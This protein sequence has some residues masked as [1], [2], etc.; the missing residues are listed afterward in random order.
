MVHTMVKILAKSIREYRK[1]AV[2]TSVLISLEVVM[3]C[4]IPFLI[5][6][7]VNEIKNGCKLE[8]I[9]RYRVLLVIMVVF[10][11]LFGALAAPPARLP[12][13]AW[14]KI[15]GRISSTVSR[16]SHLKILISFWYRHW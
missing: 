11:L 3:E 5:A 9:I 12:P 16:P 13:A 7:L 6:I 10:S 14:Q 8:V 1:S 4:I 2:L 15:C